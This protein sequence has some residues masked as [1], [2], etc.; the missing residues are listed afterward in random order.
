MPFFSQRSVFDISQ[1]KIKIVELEKITQ[2]PHFW[3]NNLEATKIEKE[4]SALTEDVK[5]WEDLENRLSV[6]HK[7]YEA[8]KLSDFSEEEK[9]AILN[10]LAIEFEKLKEDLKKEELK[11][12]LSG[13]YEDR[14]VILS[15]YSG[16]GG[17]DAQDWTA[18]LFQMYEKYAKSRGWKITILH[19]HDGDEGQGIKNASMEINGKYAFGYL[20]R[21]MGVHRLVRVSPFSAKNLRHTSFAYVEVIPEIDS[22]GEINI[23]PEDIE[24][25]TFRSSGPGGQNVNKRS[26]AV[27]L[28]HKPTGIAVS[29]QTERSQPQNRALAEKILASKLFEIASRQ[30][31]KEIKDIKGEKVS[32]EWGNQIRSYVFHPYQLVKDHRTDVET[33]DVKGALE[34]NLD[35]FIEAEIKLENSK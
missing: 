3:E 12:F 25:D 1:K 17:K 26:T 4:K 5:I 11:Y 19:K 20:S 18:L 31:A 29:V 8:A 6:L 35:K 2:D 16:A 23:N 28:V 34:G 14:P 13:K 9:E 27:R 32:I 22:V 24:L 10:D 30:K 21:E 7:D 33:S 15:V